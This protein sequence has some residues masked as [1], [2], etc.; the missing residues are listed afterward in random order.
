LDPQGEDLP[1]FR[2]HEIATRVIE[3]WA[4]CEN[5]HR[6]SKRLWERAEEHDIEAQLMA[7]ADVGSS[8]S[9]T[10]NP[11]TN[12]PNPNELEYSNDNM[13]LGDSLFQHVTQDPH[14][15]LKDD[16]F[17]QVVRHGYMSDKL[18]MLVLDKPVDHTN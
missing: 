14:P 4:L 12:G 11:V 9:N 2:Y 8:G 17:I 18:F 7:E 1:N 13:S 10:N 5:E 16:N 15:T 3:I 6:R